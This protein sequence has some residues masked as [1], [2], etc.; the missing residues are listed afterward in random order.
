[1]NS[2]LPAGRLAE[3]LDS[4]PRE[5]AWLIIIAASTAIVWM[6]NALPAIGFAPLYVPVIC[7][8]CWAL[9]P[10]RGYL[11]AVVAAFLAVSPALSSIWLF[12]FGVTALRVAIWTVALLSVAAAVTSFRRSYDREL[13]HAHRDRMTGVLNKEVFHARCAR[14][15]GEAERRGDTL[16]LVILDLDD[17]KAVNSR[18]G[19]MAGDGV[20]RAFAAGLAAIM[21]RDDLIGRIGGDEFALLARVPSWE[22]GERLARDIHGRLTAMLADSS[23]PMTCSMGAL[24]IPPGASR[25]ADA[26]MHAADQAMYR[27]KRGGKNAFLIDRP[28]VAVAAV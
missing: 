10:A 28:A 14:R 25:N 6:D 16:L 24:L 27:V 8:A 4:L 9:G 21:R 13:F 1:M 22:E 18:A 2:H 26:L 23:L 11:V 5:L 20:L 12:P 19:H 3:R 15:I 17:F 7:V